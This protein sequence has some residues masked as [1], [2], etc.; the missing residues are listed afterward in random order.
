LNELLKTLFV[1][2]ILLSSDSDRLRS[3]GVPF[4]QMADADINNSQILV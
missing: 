2:G 3:V 4:L 1:H